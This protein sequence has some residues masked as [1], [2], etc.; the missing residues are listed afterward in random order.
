MQRVIGT[1]QHYDW[2]SPTTIP[3]LLDLP[4]DGRPWAEWWLGTHSG[5]PSHLDDG[6][7]LAERT[8]PLP[9]LLKVLAAAAPLSLQTHPD[10][11]TAQAGFT[12]EQAAGV[13]IGAP[14]R[15][16]RDAS[17]KP[18]LLC[19]LEP[20]DV[21]CGFRPTEATIDLLK[22]L[23]CDRL[24]ERLEADGLEATVHALYRCRPQEDSGPDRRTEAD[25]AETLDR[26]TQTAL[27]HAH[28][29][30]AELV[31]RLSA[32][33]PNDPSVVVTLLLNRL[34][35]QPGEAVFLGPGNLHAYL[36]GTGV[37]IMGSSDNVVR[38]GL[39]SKHVD[40]EELLRVLRYEPL[41]DP[42]VRP[43]ARPTRSATV[44][45]YSTPAREFSLTRLD[46]DGEYEHHA[47]QPQLVLCTDGDAGVV[48]RGQ[49][50]L[51][52][53]GDEVTFRGRAQLFVAT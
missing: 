40:V 9:F 13:P 48:R 44:L 30:E 10:T 1:A 46:I 34:T 41:A 21:L 3:N 7:P 14:E 32:S 18:E 33:Y 24:A 4:S 12:R 26:C 39:T 15:V 8:G 17:A 28:H 37:E 31:A 27:D 52:E 16:Y 43:V 2:G 11:Q 5:A 49:T 25:I 47:E 19:A 45:S 36:H 23:R 35:L 42:V 20:F 38:G 29:R 51:L 50:L 6:T 53:A 22:S